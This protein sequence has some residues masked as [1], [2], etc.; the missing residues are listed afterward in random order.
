[1]ERI[2]GEDWRRGLVERIGGEDWWRGLVERIGGG[3]YYVDPFIVLLCKV[4]GLTVNG[5][6]RYSKIFFDPLHRFLYIGK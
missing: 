6:L 4:F 2:G 5:I 3:K 1:V